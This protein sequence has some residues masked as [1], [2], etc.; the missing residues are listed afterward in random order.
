MKDECGCFFFLFFF[1]LFFFG[2]GGEQPYYF[3][4]HGTI[5]ETLLKKMIIIS[6]CQKKILRDDR[7]D[8]KVA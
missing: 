3:E 7:G 2:G 4:I 5:I 1:F 8:K 6:E